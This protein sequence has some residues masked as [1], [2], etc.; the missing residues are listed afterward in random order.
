MANR[1]ATTDIASLAREDGWSP[2]R[3]HLGVQS[4][5]VNAWT[6]SEVGGELIGEHDEVPSGHEELYLV[7]SGRASFTVDGE[8]IDAAPGTVVFVAD[9]AV[10]RKAVAA[11]AGTTVCAVG[12]KP[13]EAYRPRSWEVNAAVFA[14]FG[15]E[16]FTDAKDMLLDALE[17]YDDRGALL[18]NLACAEARLGD[19]EAAFG[20]LERGVAER[21]DLAQLAR[22]DDD[23]AS[24]QDDPRF[25]EI[26]GTA[27]PG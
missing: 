26:L 10:K 1:Y 4:F 19:P 16:Q 2:L 6:A 15:K 24:L 20:Y 17:Q 3:K 11:E 13:G 8:E 27:T 22:R 21:P 14:L 12:G 18:Y 25:D 23:L 7:V 9:P 5:G